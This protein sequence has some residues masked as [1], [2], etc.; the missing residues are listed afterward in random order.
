MKVEKNEKGSGNFLSFLLS[1][2]FFVIIILIFYQVFEAE[3]TLSDLND[4]TWF[5]F[6]ILTLA[7][8]RLQRLLVYDKVSQWIRD[9]FLIT[10]EEHDKIT[11]ITYVIRAKHQGGIMRLFA[12]LLSCPWCVGVWAATA[13]VIIYYLFPWTWP[14]WLL[15]A[16]AGA[17]S[18]IQLTAN[19]I[20]WK[21]EGSKI[22]VERDGGERE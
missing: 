6:F 8:F 11:G 21:A 7:V 18:M 2:A 12:D 10:R 9:F 20:G 5:E 22:F 4:V 1:G 14:F 17:S 13:A 19:L 15:M 16:I 3:I